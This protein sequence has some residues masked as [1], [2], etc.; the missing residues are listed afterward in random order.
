[1]TKRLDIS[2][3][4]VQGFVSQSRRTRD[5]WGSSYLLAFLSAHAMQ[6]AHGAGGDIVHPVVQDDRL[7]RWVSGDRS[8]LPPHIGTLPNHFVVKL[9][10]EAHLVGEA[11]VAALESAWRRVCDAVWTEYVEHASS[12]GDGTQSI[13]RR[14]VCT[15]WEVSWTED[16]FQENRSL[17]A[18]RKQWRTHRPP[19][20]PGD[21]CTVMH[22]L[23]EIS[24]H[25]RTRSRRQQDEFWCQLR[26]RTGDLDLRDNERLCAVALVKRLFPRV[27]QQALGWHVDAAYWPSTVYV[28]AMPWINRVVQ[29][30]PDRARAYAAA[31]REGASDEVFRHR[32]P[33]FCGQNADAAGEFR[34][35][36]G[37]FLHYEFVTNKRLCPLADENSPGIRDRLACLLRS[38]YAASVPDAA[39]LGPPPAFYALLLADGDRLGEL[40]AGLGGTVVSKAL[41][42]FTRGLPDIVH[43]HAGVTVYAG[44]DDVLAMLPVPGALTCARDLAASYQ[45]SFAEAEAHPTRPTISAGVV[46]ANVRLPLRSVLEE[47]HRLLDTVAKE[48]NGRNSLAAA[49]LKSGGRH[50]EWVTSWMR[51]TTGG[52]SAVDQLIGLIRALGGNA[53]APGLSGS[54]IYRLRETLVALCGWDRWRPGIWGDVSGSLDLRPFLHAEIAHSAEVRMDSGAQAL[55]NDL[56][57]RVCGILS[58][59]H[60]TNDALTGIGIDALLLARFLSDAAQ[61]EHDR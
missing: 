17:L 58:R 60:A 27:S 49:V 34:K 51:P 40:V 9:R 55:A 29:A 59:S 1:M 31:V 28:G 56:T 30:V 6:G 46:F 48:V 44:G 57:D 45:T 11:A 54:L 16:T 26:Q 38:I 15:F 14:Q 36:D 32:R 50:C 10:G 53:P 23:Q 4:P 41:A 39:R 3:G 52:S 35:L 33:S 24:G 7:F 20:D 13:W 43:R 21:K 12:A 19:V 8:G 5:L 22:D 25:V 61:Q 18:R 2:I 37:N 47:A 42:S